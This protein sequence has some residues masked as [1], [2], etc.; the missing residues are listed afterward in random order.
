VSRKKSGPNSS[1]SSSSGGASTDEVPIRLAATF[2]PS[3]AWLANSQHGGGVFG[4]NMQRRPHDS[5]YVMAN[6]GV[7]LE[8]AIDAIPDSSEYIKDGWRK[9]HLYCKMSLFFSFVQREDLRVEPD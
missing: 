3:R 4:R 8:Y 5:L 1:S 2:A 7:L 6:H 9:M